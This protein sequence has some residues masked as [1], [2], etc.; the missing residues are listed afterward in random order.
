MNHPNIVRYHTSWTEVDETFNSFSGIEGA[1]ESGTG[2]GTGF[3]SEAATT[4]SGT[5]DSGTQGSES[6]SSTEQESDSDSSDSV[7]DFDEDSSPGA[8][9]DMDF[10][11]DLD[12]IDFLSVGHAQSRSMSYPSIHFGNE[13]D[14]SR[15][16]S[17][18]GTNSAVPSKK[19]TRAST[20]NQPVVAPTPPKQRRTLYIQVSFIFV[21]SPRIRTVRA[22]SLSRYQMEYVEKLTLREAIED[23]ITEVDSWR[24]LVS[25]TSGDIPHRSK[26]T[27]LAPPVSNPIC[28]VA[29]HFSQ[30]S[31]S[32]CSL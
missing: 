32:F 7:V 12:D 20:P 29:F 25:S 11:D 1:S 8:D 22:E 21:T 26:L 10:G 17:S 13:D 18:D 27:L 19:T 3:T 28:H 24:L 16:N 30:V 5:Q 6:E 9:L 31:F 15:P 4:D 14:P 23:G 2:T